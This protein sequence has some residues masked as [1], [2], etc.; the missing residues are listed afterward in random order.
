MLPADAAST[1]VSS[2]WKEAVRERKAAA[3]G[4]CHC[5]GGGDVLW[6]GGN[7]CL[8]LPLKSCCGQNTHD[9][10]EGW[11][12]CQDFSVWWLGCCPVSGCRSQPQHSPPCHGQIG[13]VEE[14]RQ[15]IGA[16]WWAAGAHVAVLPH[17]E[18]LK[19]LNMVASE[20]CLHFLL[21]P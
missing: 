18:K 15:R 19:S 1:L 4:C 2:E 9:G 11:L 14:L 17:Q 16:G 3:C 6:Q 5:Q 13:M 7:T 21:S 12:H 8:A 20:N 10:E